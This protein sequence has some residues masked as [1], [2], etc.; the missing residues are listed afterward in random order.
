MFIRREIVGGD[1]LLLPEDLADAVRP[2]ALA[3]VQQQ[4][5]RAASEVHHAVEVL[6]LAGLRFLAVECDDRGEDIRDPLRRV[7]F[8]GLLARARGELAD[9]VLVGVA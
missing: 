1:V 2:H 3:N 6:L 5:A 9:Q 4:R 7:E 8:T